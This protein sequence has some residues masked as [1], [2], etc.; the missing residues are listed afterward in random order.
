M[1]RSNIQSLLRIW[2]KSTT[3]EKIFYIAVVVIGL[4][5]I[6]T[7]GNKTI[8]N[9]Q[10]STRFITKRGPEIYDDFYVSVYDD[11]L[12]SEFKNHYEIGEIINRTSP[13]AQSNILDIGSGTGHHVGALSQKGF[14]CQGIDI[15]PA[16]VKK[17]KSNYPDCTFK[18][19]D[20]L[21]SIL[22]QPGQFTH[23][24]CLYFTIYMIRD[25]RT[26]FQNCMNWLRPGGYLVIH[27]VNRDKFD[28]ILP[29]ADILAKIDPQDYADTRITSTKAAFQNHLYEAN[30]ELKGDKAYFKEKFIE[31]KNNGV[32]QNNH[33]LYMPTQQEILA[34]ASAAGFVLVSKTEMKRVKYNNQYIYVL[35]K[36][37]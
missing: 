12:Y 2:K 34:K 25:K 17:A 11:L 29:V 6:G 23:I 27:L 28:P 7:F 22:F 21:K 32:R 20:A 10:Q 15:A 33:E 19:G 5:V 1:A 24:T 30:F 26:F 14:K 31:K 9:F 37:Q 8:E 4:Y 36:P 35:Q 16:M 18:T 3:I 13:T